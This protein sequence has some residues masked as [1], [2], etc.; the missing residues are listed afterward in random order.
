MVKTFRQLNPI[1]NISIRREEKEVEREV[2]K[3]ND[4]NS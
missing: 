4:D 2:T 1:L 3:K